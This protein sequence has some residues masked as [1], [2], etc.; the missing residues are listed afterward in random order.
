MTLKSREWFVQQFSPLLKHH[1]PGRRTFALRSA[2]HARQQTISKAKQKPY[3]Q[4]NVPLPTS[5]LHKISKLLSFD[6]EQDIGPEKKILDIR[7]L[8]K[9][10]FD[11]LFGLDAIVPTVRISNQKRDRQTDR[12]TELRD[13]SRQ[14]ILWTKMCSHQFQAFMLHSQLLMERLEKNHNQRGRN[15]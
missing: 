14:Q 2:T 4:E 7:H 9:F 5:V 15:T 12:P 13:H 3:S 11:F 6:L 10:G 8:K 1:F